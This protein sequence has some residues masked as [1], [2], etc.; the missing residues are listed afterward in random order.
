M[1]PLQSI[2]ASGMSIGRSNGIDRLA[3][4]KM[5]GAD[6]ATGAEKVGFVDAIGGA[7]DKVNQLQESSANL[8]KEFQMENPDVGLEETM[9]AM[10]KASLGFQAAVQVRNKVV[11][12]YN[13]IMN[14]NV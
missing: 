10:Q 6:Q 8:S 9:I 2:A 7:L 3:G 11:Q 5:P 14:M 13:D 12:A 1:D 4:M